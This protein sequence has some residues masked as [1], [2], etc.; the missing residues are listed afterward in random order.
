MF[1]R[2]LLNRVTT[3]STVVA[4]ALVSLG[5]DSHPV[6]AADGNRPNIIYIM[7]DDMG[8][9]DL[10]CYGQKQIQTPHLDRMADEGVRFT[11]FYA[12]STVC[13]PSMVKPNCRLCNVWA[14][15]YC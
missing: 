4:T 8:Y 10:G 3:L 9:G 1:P 13:A 12:G 2:R 14:R 5:I 15:K 7:A 6:I 11:D